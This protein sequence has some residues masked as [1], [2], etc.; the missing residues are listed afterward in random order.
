MV[1]VVGCKWLLSH[2]RWC[3]CWLLG[4]VRHVMMEGVCWSAASDVYKG[5]EVVLLNGVVDT[6]PLGGT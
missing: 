5:Q 3:I 2:G 6:T 4:W 1:G